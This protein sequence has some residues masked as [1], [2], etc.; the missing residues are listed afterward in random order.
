MAMAN[1]LDLLGMTVSGDF[2]G[3]TIYTDRHGRKV[4]YPQ[5][6]PTNPPTQRQQYRRQLFKLAVMS[7]KSLTQH[8]R[9]ALERAVQKT[10]LCL[11]GQNLWISCC[12]NSDLARYQTI[13]RQAHE[14]LPPLLFVS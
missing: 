2:A 5:A 1:R 6:P 10:N 11:T 3:L 7:Y 13:A 9:D 8:E 12:L 4:W 14:T